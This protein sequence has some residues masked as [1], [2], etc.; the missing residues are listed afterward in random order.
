[1]TIASSFLNTFMWRIIWIINVSTKTRDTISVIGHIRSVRKWQFTEVLTGL[2]YSPQCFFLIS[3]CSL[4]IIN[5]ESMLVMTER[6]W[7][8]HVS[9]THRQRL[10]SKENG[11]RGRKTT[12]KIWCLAQYRVWKIHTTIDWL[13]KYSNWWEC[14]KLS[15]WSPTWIR[16][17]K[18]PEAGFWETGGKKPFGPTPKWDA[19]LELNSSP[20]QALTVLR[21]TW[22]N[23]LTVQVFGVMWLWWRQKS[24]QSHGT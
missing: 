21:E 4:S 17:N 19:D 16:A 14:S 9:Y 24:I 8:A 13:V 2:G 11:I 10:E 23:E 7:E 15:L 5:S 22:A 20:P 3:F 12:E 6:S 1:M 18:N